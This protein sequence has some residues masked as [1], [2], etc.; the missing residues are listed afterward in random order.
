MTQK[1]KTPGLSVV[2]KIDCCELEFPKCSA[3]IK[4]KVRVYPQAD[5]ERTIASCM[6]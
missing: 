1:L 4:S 3:K 2:T 5:V 6:T